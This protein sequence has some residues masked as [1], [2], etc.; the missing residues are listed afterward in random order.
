MVHIPFY[1][2]RLSRG[3]PEAAVSVQGRP[4]TLTAKYPC[5]CCPARADEDVGRAGAGPV[6]TEACR[7]SGRSVFSW[8]SWRMEALC[9]TDEGGFTL[10]EVLAVITFPFH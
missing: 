7:K 2:P 9:K 4:C 3:N 10:I 8:F 6:A 5:T 1:P